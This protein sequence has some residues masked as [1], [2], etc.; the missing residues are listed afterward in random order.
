MA[1]PAPFSLSS[2]PFASKSATSTILGPAVLKIGNF[3]QTHFG[4]FTALRRNQGFTLKASMG[5]A[6][7]TEKL[8]NNRLKTLA[9]AEDGCDI[10]N[11]LKDRFLS[12]KKNKYMKNI[13]QFENL[14]KV[15]TPKFMVIA[16]ADSRVCPS[17][18]LGFQPGEAFMIRNVANLVP[19]FE[20]GPSETN[21]ALEFAVNSLLVENILVI[22]HSCC[23]GIRAL[24][25]MQDDDVERSSFIKSWVIVGK[26]A[27]KKAKAAASNFSFDEQCKHC[28]KESINH[29]LLNLLTYPWIEEK[30][31]N[32]ELSIHGGYYDFTD[33][34]FEKWTLDYRGTK[35]EENGSIATKNKIFWC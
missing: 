19:T 1:V 8:N 17:N 30:V 10:F 15:Q 21:A 16:C 29:S 27:R 12:F 18:V 20:S 24:M 5:P 26:N 31:A 22:G 33:C 9:D 23:G 7:F 25:G 13:E 3:E 28:E 2:D 11:D 35:L 32:G 34:S 4:L 6:G 14:A